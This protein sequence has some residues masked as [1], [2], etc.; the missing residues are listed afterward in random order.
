MVC[1]RFREYEVK[2]LRPP[3]C[4]RQQNAMFPP[5]VHGTW[6]A[7]L[8]P[9]LYILFDLN[10]NWL[11]RSSKIYWASQQLIGRVFMCLLSGFAS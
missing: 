6:S 11:I 5:H 4:S 3:A 1:S 7:P 9:P 8:S 10:A 2:K